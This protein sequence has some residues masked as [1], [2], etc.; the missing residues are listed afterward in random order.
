MVCA[1]E[2]EGCGVYREKNAED[3]AARQKKKK[4]RKANEEVHGGGKGG[5]TKGWRDR[6]RCS[7]QS[8]IE[9]DDRLW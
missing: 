5:Q 1:R 4:K 7:E 3:E 9:T 6:G 2:K 8:E